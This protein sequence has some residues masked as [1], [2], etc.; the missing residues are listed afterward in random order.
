[1]SKE[2]NRK[3]KSIILSDIQYNKSIGYQDPYVLRASTRG[4]LTKVNDFESL[5]QNIESY[6]YDLRM[7]DEVN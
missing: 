4:R 7:N 5:H 1:M 6:L 2:L 3:Q